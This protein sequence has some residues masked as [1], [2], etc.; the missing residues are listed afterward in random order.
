MYC[1][2]LSQNENYFVLNF[3]PALLLQIRTCI[4]GNKMETRGF[5]TARNSF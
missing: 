1:S 2:M 3:F 4:D 5:K